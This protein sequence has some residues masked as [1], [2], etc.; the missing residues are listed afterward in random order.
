MIQYH[1]VRLMSLLSLFFTFNA[2]STSLML[3]TIKLPHS[4]SLMP[5]R[6]YYDGRIIQSELHTTQSKINYEIPWIH[7]QATLYILVTEAIEEVYKRSPN[8]QGSINTIDYLKVPKQQNY[9]LYKLDLMI[10][11]TLDLDEKSTIKTY[12]WNI[13]E[14][15][16]AINRRIPDQTIIIIY[17]PEFVEALEGGTQLEIP[18]IIM[19][20]NSFGLINTEKNIYEKL[21]ELQ[22]SA[23]DNNTIHAPIK[24]TVQHTTNKTIIIGSTT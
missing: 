24:K 10:K 19:K 5:L 13:Q 12:S 20:Q 22:L 14:I 3:G 8:I 17:I 23:V 18:T 2:H 4:S 15:D 21:I 11:E 7:G 6:M 16:L 1:T 9:K